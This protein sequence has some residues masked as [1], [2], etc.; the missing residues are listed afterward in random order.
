MAMGVSASS[1]E[2]QS[3]TTD[4]S[5][6]TGSVIGSTVG[7]ADSTLSGGGAVYSSKAAQTVNVSAPSELWP[8]LQSLGAG[9]G[10]LAGMAIQSSG[11]TTAQSLALKANL[12]NVT[13]DKT[14]QLYIFAGVAIVAVL[15]FLMFYKRK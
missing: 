11:D 9:V 13:T 15:L 14:R 2:S 10:N 8:F 5:V 4:K 12:E 3:A 6:A 1:S 7:G